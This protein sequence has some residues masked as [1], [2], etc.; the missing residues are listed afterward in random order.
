MRALRLCAGRLILNGFRN[1][2]RRRP[3]GLFQP[4]QHKP[5]DTSELEI[6]ESAHIPAPER[7]HLIKSEEAGLQLNI[8]EL[9][10]GRELLCTF[11]TLRDIKVRYKQTL[12]GFAWVIIQPLTTMLIFTLV[13][14]RFV[15]LGFRERCAIRFLLFLV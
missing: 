1:Q 6:S 9:W 12:M 2:Q 10:A 5:Y 15:R 8:G 4:H 13:F 11:L 7:H 14:K 3:R